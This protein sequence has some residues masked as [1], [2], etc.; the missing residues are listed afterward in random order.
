MSQKPPTTPP[1]LLI[2]DDEPDAGRILSR[3]LGEQ[4]FAVETAASGEEGLRSVERRAPDLVLLDV[5]LPT[6]DGIETLRR[7]KALRPQTAVIMMT[8][9]EAVKTAVE[10]MKCGAYDYLPKPLPMDRLPQILRQALQVRALEQSAFSKMPTRPEPVAPEEMVGQHL[11]MVA[12]FDLVRRIAPQDLTVLIRGES[13]TGKELIA[14]AI[15]TLSLKREKPFVPVDCASLPEPLFESELFG[16]ERGAFTGADAPKE[17]RFEQAEGG[18]L[19][20]DEIGNLTLAA[21]AK[22]LRVLQEREIIRLGGKRPIKIHVRILAATNQ[23][24]ENLMER[25]LFREDL[26]HRLNVFSITLPPLRHRGEDVKLLCRFFINR[27]N[28]ELG[29]RVCGISDEAMKLLSSYFWP[30]NVREL[31]NTVKG[32]L[33]LA[34]E[35][36]FPEHLPEKV[37]S[38][39]ARGGREEAGLPGNGGPLS[40]GSLRE[41]SRRAA[42]GTEKQLILR[43]LRETHGN[44]RASAQRLGIDYK[45]LFNKL[46]AFGVTKDQVEEMR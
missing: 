7:I 19:F 11:S 46:K 3:I 6:W 5:A 44:K 30:G 17:G 38:M 14:R 41:I 26:F 2:I 1:R 43:T 27:F 40:S 15:H 9:H 37:Q 24:L 36:I 32:A 20:L 16:Y 34:D 23:N 31:E 18:T 22:L 28:Q 42:E 4:G 39:G 29:K 21:Q 13:G 45:T 35:E 8:G 12:I 33:L 10:A 25:Q